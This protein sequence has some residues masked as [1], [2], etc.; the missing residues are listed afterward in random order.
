MSESEPS[1]RVCPQ[2]PDARVRRTERA[3]HEALG[4]LIRQRPYERIVVKQILAQARV[5]RSTFYAHFLDKDDL[6]IRSLDEL[7][8]D[9]EC[10][11]RSHP[12]REQRILGFGR[13]L[14]EHIVTH[15]QG[16]PSGPAIDQ[17]A[18][19]RKL[20]SLLAARIAS[21]LGREVAGG[22][23]SPV[24]LDLLASHIAASLMRSL[25]RAMAQQPTPS[26]SDADRVFR[27]LVAPIL[28]S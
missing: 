12:E 20:E 15:R 10:I 24:P 26:A 5:A 27:A 1:C 8:R 3:L 25:D 11:A 17:K 2:T 16:A 18:L 4:S 13:V 14:Y 7:L 23:R 9:A 6:L 22:W 19:H 28:T 21:Q